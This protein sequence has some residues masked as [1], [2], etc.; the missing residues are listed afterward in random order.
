MKMTLTTRDKKLLFYLLLF[1]MITLGGHFLI[2]KP[3]EEQ[4]VLK[5]SLQELITQKTSMT[6]EMAQKTTY[7]E[8]IKQTMV[9]I[10]KQQSILRQEVV[11]EEIDAYLTS[12]LVANDLKPIMLSFGNITGG[13]RGTIDE[14]YVLE[15]QVDI[16]FQGKRESIMNLLDDLSTLP[17]AVVQNL[18]INS[19]QKIDTHALM[20]TVY[21]KSEKLL[22]V[23]GDE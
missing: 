1:S 20:L 15:L 22:E 13:T 14:A 18:Q 23:I 4:K 8:E 17:D 19:G 2:L 3:L 10:K 16:Q 5:M 21:M 9:Q 11:K 6:Y 7:E 12:L